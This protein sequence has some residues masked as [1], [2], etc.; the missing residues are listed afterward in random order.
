MPNIGNVPRRGWNCQ[1]PQKQ[2]NVA[3]PLVQPIVQV[4][5]LVLTRIIT[6]VLS[7]IKSYIKLGDVFEYTKKCEAYEFYGTVA[8]G[9]ANRWIKIIEKPLTYCN[10]QRKKG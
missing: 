6:I 8:F 9:Q 2:E 3:N 4:D 5:A 7:K 1:P 10:S